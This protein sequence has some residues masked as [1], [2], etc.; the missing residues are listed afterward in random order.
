M[1]AEEQLDAFVTNHLSPR[2][3][4]TAGFFEVSGPPSDP[5]VVAAQML[6]NE[7][8][9][10]VK[11]GVGYLAPTGV[12]T[13]ATKQLLASFQQSYNVGP[14]DGMPGLATIAALEKAVDEK[15]EL[16]L[17]A[18]AS[19]GSSAASTAARG[20]FHV[21]ADEPDYSALSRGCPRG[22]WWDSLRGKCR[23]IAPLY[24]PMPHAVEGDYPIHF[25]TPRSQGGMV[26]LVSALQDNGI[27]MTGE[28]PRWTGRVGGVLFTILWDGPDE[29][30]RVAVLD[31]R[32]GANLTAFW[33]S[34]DALLGRN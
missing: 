15:R 7:L 2:Y 12:L 24:P 14:G 1:S 21:G 9:G 11:G 28:S 27:A 33:H 5:M 20:M 6:L 22:T 32:P 10:F 13:P 23:P 17:H 34:I 25:Y 26:D 29:S 19:Q 31:A 30:L 18:S 16:L 4:L 3:G 8:W